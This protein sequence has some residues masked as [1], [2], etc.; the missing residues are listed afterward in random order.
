MASENP[1]DS[2]REGS[3][4]KTIRIFSSH[5]AANIAAA[6]LEAHGIRCWITADD[7]GGMLPNLATPGGVRL[8]VPA[9]DSAAASALLSDQDSGG[10]IPTQDENR[11]KTLFSTAAGPPPRLAPL[12]ILIGVFLGVLLCLLYGDLAQRGTTTRY[13]HNLDGRL[14]KKWTYQNGVLVEFDRDRNLD[15]EWD[16]WTY[17]EHGA[18]ARSLVDNNFDGK[19]DE[20]WTYS[21]GVLTR[22]EKDTDFNGVPDE[23]CT[24]ANGVIQRVDFMPN[25]A[26]FSTQRQLFR[27]GVLVE[28]LRGGD[29]A[30]NFKES[31]QYGP[32]FNPVS[33][34]QLR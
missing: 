1:E 34:N 7:A 24:Y 9:S 5:D 6:S 8:A 14:D 18:I 30:G 31:V 22:M 15:G 25:G 12:Q 26:K 23:F 19:P 17:Y 32:F 21:N 16:E 4:A 29:E 3:E 10:E 27:H 28:I 11:A 13:H 2:A 20:T 33:T